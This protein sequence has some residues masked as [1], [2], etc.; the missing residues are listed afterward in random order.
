MGEEGREKSR[1][2]CLEGSWELAVGLREGRNKV[3]ACTS[4]CPKNR[5][6]QG[7]FPLQCWV[8]AVAEPSENEEVPWGCLVASPARQ[9][10]K[11]LERGCLSSPSQR[12]Q[13]GPRRSCFGECWAIGHIICSPEK[14]RGRSIFP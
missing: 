8:R 13:Q 10:N 9:K 7:V 11:S 6:I 3:V 4:C 12:E 14:W 5:E 2:Q 1:Y